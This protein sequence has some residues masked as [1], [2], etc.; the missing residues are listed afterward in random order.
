MD[1]NYEHIKI[2]EIKAMFF[3][4]NRGLDL[5]NTSFNQIC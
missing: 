4:L 1:M 3:F 5:F 2:F